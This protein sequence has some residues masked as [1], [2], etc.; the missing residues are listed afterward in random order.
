MLPFIV[1]VRCAALPL[2]LRIYFLRISLTK[3]QV[4]MVS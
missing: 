1:A 3:R 4:G 2:R